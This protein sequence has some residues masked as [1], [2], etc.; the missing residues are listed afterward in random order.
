MSSSLRSIA[1]N[2][3]GTLIAVGSTNGNLRVYEY[4][5]YPRLELISLRWNPDRANVKYSTELKGHTAAIEKVAFNPVKDAVLCSV[6]S[7]GNV[8]FWDVKTK[9]VI[10]EVKGLGDAFTLA[11]SPD[12]ETLVVGNKV[13]LT[14]TGM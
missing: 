13:R 1:W 12:G 9:E 11:W 7:D 5:T 10:N 14:T 8:K 2:P 6:S 4:K 3:L